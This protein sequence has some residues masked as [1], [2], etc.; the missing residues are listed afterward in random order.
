MST[1]TEPGAART[2]KVEV[3]LPAEFFDLLEKVCKI[4]E[5]SMNDYLIYGAVVILDGD[6]DMHLSDLPDLGIPG[7]SQRAYVESLAWPKRAQEE[8]EA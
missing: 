5:M 8:V 2:K 4:Q 1:K 6:L 7:G 3:E